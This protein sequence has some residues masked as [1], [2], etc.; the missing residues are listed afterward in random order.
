MM[1][2]SNMSPRER[3]LAFMD[4][5]PL[6]YLPF[7][8]KVSKNYIKYREEQG[9]IITEEVPGSPWVWIDDC[10]THQ[11]KLWKCEFTS[12]SRCETFITPYGTTKILYKY[13]EISGSY[14][15][16]E[17]AIT[18]VEDIK[19]MT[20]WFLSVKPELDNK[21][22]KEALKTIKEVNLNQTG[23]TSSISA[24]SPFLYYIVH[25]AG[26]ENGNYL[27]F[28]HEDEVKALLE[29]SQAY[30]KARIKLHLESL[31]TDLCLLIENMSTMLVSPNQYRDFVIKDIKE[32]KGICDNN[33]G[34]LALQM[35]GHIS[36]ILNELSDL[37]SLIIEGV[38]TPPVG[39]TTL[40]IARASCKEMR[41]A[42]GTNA[43]LWL[44]SSDKV[45]AS[46]EEDL[47]VMSHHLGLAITS[48]DIIPPD[49]P[50]N[51]IVKVADFIKNYKCRF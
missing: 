32:L 50:F 1:L 41:I 23:I 47:N 37:E 31:Q 21:R 26:V 5:K 43:A 22:L 46:L 25:L 9:D 6:D 35:P 34:R 2:T 14:Y 4:A 30:M 12:T 40:S 24:I 48:S 36:A 19:I 17:H 39:N 8:A 27:L 38:C 29:A 42:G 33:M 20:E 18:T 10:I 28:E 7:W 16:E 15:P 44:Q 13:D 45:I 49:T 51:T 3:W 11:D